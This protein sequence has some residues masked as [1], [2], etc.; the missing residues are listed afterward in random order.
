MWT[1]RFG[2][3]KYGFKDTK[4]YPNEERHKEIGIHNR[5]E[6]KEIHPLPLFCVDL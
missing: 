2:V 4:E 1:H 6:A 5:F 3:L